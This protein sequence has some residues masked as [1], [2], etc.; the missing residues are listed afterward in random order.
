[1]QKTVSGW[2]GGVHRDVTC[3]KCHDPSVP[4]E[5]GNLLRVIPGGPATPR[6]LNFAPDKCL[7]CHPFNPR[8]AKIASDVDADNQHADLSA[9][10]HAHMQKSDCSSC[11]GRTAHGPAELKAGSIASNIPIVLD[12][13]L[14]EPAWQSAEILRVPIMGG[15]TIGRITVELKAF[16]S[17]DYLYLAAKWPDPRDDAEKA[18]WQ[19]GEDGRWKKQG[20]LR[21]GEAGNEDRVMF[22]WDVSVP[23]FAR[24]GCLVTCHADVSASKYLESPG[25]GDLWHW[26]AARSNPAGYCDDTYIDHVRMS[27]DG[28]RHG[29]STKLNW[30]TQ[31]ND[32]STGD[33]PGYMPQPGAIRP[34]ARFLFAKD[35]VPIPPGTVWPAGTK[36]PGYLLSRPDGSRGDI[37]AKG[38]WEN[39][40]W[41]VEFRR[42]LV[43]GNP[44]D[45]NFGDLNRPYL[46]GLAVSDNASGAEHSFSGVLRLKFVK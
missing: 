8:W 7:A 36:I 41:T 11:H 32:N 42:R 13:R 37:S 38:L 33:G 31:P 44:D 40:F 46:F 28:G 30:G 5:L 10:A 17:G 1:M 34:D 29:D 24:E 4:L 35:A 19:M 23:N 45:V 3:L 27:D 22:L 25:I 18:V 14:D 15:N 20:R 12:G 6:P 9:V 39:G 43:T 16:R 26:K 2:S 21:A